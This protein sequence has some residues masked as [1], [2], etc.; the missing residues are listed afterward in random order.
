MNK[1]AKI[2]VVVAGLALVAQVAKAN[3]FD[4][5][6]GFNGNGAT[7]DYVINLGNAN[8]SVG[9]G[10]GQV[11][12]LSSFFNAT[13]FNSIF[14]AGVNGTLMGA[15]GGQNATSPTLYYTENRGAAGNASSALSLAPTLTSTSFAKNGAGNFNDLPNTFSGLN[16]TGG[17]LTVA[18][19]DPDS[20]SSQITS[21]NPGSFTS[22]T[23]LNS[24]SSAIGSGVIYEDLWQATKS[25]N[26]MVWTYTGYLTF[27][28]TGSSP[29]LTFSAVPV[30]EPSTYGLFGAAGVLVLALR[31]RFSHKNA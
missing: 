15:G 2:A 22:N 17:N 7:S 14:T 13:T 31:R 18:S 25:G 5:I 6:L 12:D 10:S 3:D 24:P 20:W 30:P 11:T 21:G 29:S 28:D 9:V 26:K 1:L 27:D 19:S 16:S 8:T 4:I 23:G